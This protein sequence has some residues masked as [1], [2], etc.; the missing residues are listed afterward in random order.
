M[1]IFKSFLR[2]EGKGTYKQDGLYVSGITVE[3]IEQYDIIGA[4][5]I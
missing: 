2:A 1:N 5:C 4:I 3:L